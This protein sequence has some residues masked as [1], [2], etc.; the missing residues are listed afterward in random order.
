MGIRGKIVQNSL[1]NLKNE[2]DY[3]MAEESYQNYKM[4]E[5]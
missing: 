2:E 4:A 3:K 5:E 1:G